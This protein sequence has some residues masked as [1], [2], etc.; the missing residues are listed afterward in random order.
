MGAKV[1]EKHFTILPKNQTKDGPVSA[2]PDELKSISKICK[3]KSND[4]KKYI[5][6]NI[7]E[8]NIMLGK[9]VRELSDIE[10]LNRDYYQGRFASKIEG[11]YVFNWDEKKINYN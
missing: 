8:K 5:D 3:M 1:V 6:E 7:P 9:E 2:N 10:L 4:L 11:K